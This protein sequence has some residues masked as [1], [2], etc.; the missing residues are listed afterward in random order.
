MFKIQEFLRNEKYSLEVLYDKLAT[1]PYNLKI[2]R[3][4]GL[5]LFHYSINSDFSLP[6]V[7]EARSLILEEENFNVVCHSFNRFYNYGE[8]NAA[9]ID[10]KSVRVFEKVD[11][12]II[13]LYWWN[14]EWR[15]STTST[16]NANRAYVGNTTKTYSKLFW[17]AWKHIDLRS[18][19]KNYT[20]TFEIVSPDINS[21]VRY[22]KTKLY[23][24]GTFDNV[25][26]MEVEVN[27][28]VQK[29]H[30][31]KFSSLNDCIE[32][33]KN[34]VAADHE[35]FVAVDGE[36]NRIKIKAEDWV[37]AHKLYNNSKPTTT[38][39]IEMIRSGEI[40]EYLAY[41][42]AAAEDFQKVK[43]TYELLVKDYKWLENDVL[44][45]MSVQFRNKKG[46]A[47]AVQNFLAE[48]YHSFAFYVFDRG[49]AIDWL[50]S[51]SSKK[52]AELIEERERTL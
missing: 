28:G 23:H 20:Y 22:D 3:E 12:S 1:K 42:P 15:T 43:R 7:N 49:N 34:T 48:K 38:N 51:L 26:E 46:Y 16:I 11:G 44:Y 32:F 37:K 33:N 13:R 10:W 19:N 24:I 6:I 14:G 50:N 52:L 9:T 25:N 45:S 41:F 29:P 31:Y 4:N 36:Y 5:A 39:W 35:G 47:M 30:L 18:L 27:I 8:K 40:D 2:K 17:K 21:V